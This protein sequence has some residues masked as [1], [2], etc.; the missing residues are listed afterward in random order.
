MPAIDAFQTYS[1]GLSDTISI[2][3]AVT[4][5]DTVDLTNA[6]R[7]LYIGSAGNLR[8][9]MAGGMVANFAN[10]AAGFAPLRVTRVHA[11]GTTASSIIGCS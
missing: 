6:T 9:T 2:T 4:P 5:S 7:S 10:V 11:T 8:V 3:E 1:T